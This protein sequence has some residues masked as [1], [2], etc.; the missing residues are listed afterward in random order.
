MAVISEDAL[1][2][3]FRAAHTQTSWRDEPVSEDEL[4]AL[5]DLLKFA[6]TSGNGWPL[7]VVYATS[8]EAKQALAE[9]SMEGNREK[10]VT[11]PAVA[12]LAHDLEFYTRMDVL[13]PHNDE[14]PAMFAGNRELAEVTAFRNGS[15]Q[16]AY[17][18]LAARAI[19][20]DCAPMSGF[21]NDAVD[22][23]HFADTS[24]R[25][26][27]LCAIGHGDPETVHPRLPRP[28]FDDVCRIV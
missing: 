1:D 6:P 23:L 17:F 26:N 19:G 18:I 3:L 20:L 13:F 28:S 9:R 21:N 5:H 10:I 4:R 2:Q 22:Q 12:V 8:A 11:A 14:M 24:V 25:S 27:I 16:C 7:R 15:L